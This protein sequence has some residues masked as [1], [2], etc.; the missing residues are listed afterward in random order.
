MSCVGLHS[1]Q[2]VL[3]HAY[4][5][6][7]E[8]PKEEFYS[9]SKYMQNRIVWIPFKRTLLLCLLFFFTMSFLNEGP[10]FWVW[11]SWIPSRMPTH[12]HCPKGHFGCCPALGWADAPLTKA[13]SDSDRDTTAW[14]PKSGRHLLMAP[15]IF[16]S[17]MSFKGWNIENCCYESSCSVYSSSIFKSSSHVKKP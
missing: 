16:A 5:E 2:E 15:W 10:N 13:A 6:N 14:D 12:L 1:W 8:M 11:R 7:H 4:S 3:V 9:N 17:S